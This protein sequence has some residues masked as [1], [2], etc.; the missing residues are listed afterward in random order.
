MSGR[1]AVEFDRVCKDYRQ[2]LRGRTIRALDKVSFCVPTGEVVGIVGPNRAGKT[3]LVKI[4]L[5][6]CHPTSGCIQ[7]LGRPVADRSTLA[8][9]GYVHE[10]QAFPHYLTATA[11]LEYYGALT[12]MPRKV[13]R[14]RAAEL[15][16]QMGLADRS[17]E[18]I[19]RFSKGMLQRLALAQALLNEPDLLVLDE[20]SE[21]MDLHARRLLFD[22]IADTRAEDRTVILVSHALADIQRVCDRVAVVREGRLVAYDEVQEFIDPQSSDSLEDAIE[23]LYAE[24]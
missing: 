17:R 6:I 1:M 12:L 11:L 15:L 13:A 8:R 22:A 9:V 10:S 7:R 4:L 16:D 14:W 3:T 23:P 20:P 5:S 18:P 19:G 21:G 2:G 24:V